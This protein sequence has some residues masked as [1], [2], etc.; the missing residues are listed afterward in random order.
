MTCD[1]TVRDVLI[2]QRK[3][4]HR[5]VDFASKTSK[6]GVSNVIISARRCSRRCSRSSGGLTIAALIGQLRNARYAY[7]RCTDK[8]WETRISFRA[9]H[10]TDDDSFCDDARTM[11]NPPY[12]EMTNLSVAISG[13]IQFTSYAHLVKFER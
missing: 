6:I 9:L 11:R 8:G 13:A 1:V 5:R 7:A 10:V 3:N 4:N 12:A 2:E